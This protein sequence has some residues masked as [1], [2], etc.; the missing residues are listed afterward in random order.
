MGLRAGLSVIGCREAKTEREVGLQRWRA[1]QV[2]AIT[3]SAEQQQFYSN[4]L[5]VE[6]SKSKM[7]A[8]LLDNSCT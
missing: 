2:K 6:E 1:L 7:S 8:C 5:Y 4:Q 3:K